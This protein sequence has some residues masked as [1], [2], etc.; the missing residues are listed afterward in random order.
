ME[1]EVF[2]RTMVKAFQKKQKPTNFLRNFFKTVMLDGI[3]AE[4][5]GQDVKATYSVDNQIGTGG[6]RHEFSYHE[7]K[8]V[9]VPEYNDFTTLSEVDV[10]K[11][12]LGD[13]NYT[14]PDK[15]VVK[16]VANRQALFSDMQRRAEE[17]QASDALFNGKVVLSNGDEIE[18]RKKET[19]NYKPTK[20]W[21]D[22]TQDAIADIEKM[23]Q[24]CI[25][26]GKISPSEFHL[27]LESKGLNALLKNKSFRDNADLTKNIK[28]ADISMPVEKTPGA[29]F[30]GQFSAG[31]YIVNLWSYNAK[32]EIPKGFGFA[33]EGVSVPYVPAG[34][35]LILPNEPEFECYYGAV[36][37]T[38]GAKPGL[39]GGVLN[40]EKVE[41]L[42][43]AYDTL[44]NGSGVTYA[45]VKSRP[46][47]Y[48]VNI[49]S[50]ATLDGIA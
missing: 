47:L 44:L 34:K 45:G 19:H 10:F 31:A 2:Y 50:M 4:I 17:K 33:N 23:C 9:V 49:D 22:D 18:Y 5:Q 39:I 43:Y 40:L 26:D 48:P 20:K 27:I 35:G 6:N 37:N 12:E 36:N 42:P 15:V 8:E 41:Q 32:Y 21:T 25:D 7:T 13:T 16:K 24:L 1:L 38:N 14:V 29:K 3:V 11:K 28:R 46:L 30:H